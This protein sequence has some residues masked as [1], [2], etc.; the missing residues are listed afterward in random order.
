M[1]NLVIETLLCVNLKPASNPNESRM[2]GVV[3]M[4]VAGC[5]NTNTMGTCNLYLGELKKYY[6]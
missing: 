1:D 2:V 6:L 3:S 5:L 4:D